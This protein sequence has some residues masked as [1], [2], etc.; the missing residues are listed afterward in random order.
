MRGERGISSRL[1]KLMALRGYTERRYQA[2]HSRAP[3]A[4][5]SF[6]V[7]AKSTLIHLALLMRSPFAS[8]CVKYLVGPGKLYS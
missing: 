3:V 4:I 7:L 8:D 5:D 6:A 2:R 1:C